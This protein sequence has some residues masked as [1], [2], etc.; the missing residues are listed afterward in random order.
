MSY[1]VYLVFTNNSGEDKIIRVFVNNQDKD[2]VFSQIEKLPEKEISRYGESIEVS[3][4]SFRI[5]RKI[6]KSFHKGILCFPNF[7]N[8]QGLFLIIGPSSTNL[9][10]SISNSSVD[11]KIDYDIT[12]K[13]IECQKT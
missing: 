12:V 6:L 1:S 3:A 4:E 11:L 9:F 7:K 2:R 5:S 10:K 13:Y 8:K